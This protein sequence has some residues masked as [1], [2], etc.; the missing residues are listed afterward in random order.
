MRN[1]P[2]LFQVHLLTSRILRA[3]KNRQPNS[4]SVVLNKDL[5]PPKHNFLLLD[6]ELILLNNLLEMKLLAR[7]FIRNL[8][9]LSNNQVLIRLLVQAH[10]MVSIELKDLKIPLGQSVLARETIMKESQE[11]HRTSLHQILTTQIS[12]VQQTKVP[13]GFSVLLREEA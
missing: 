13:I 5:L 7:L 12:R 8:L 3:S 9:H 6:L 10:M 2:N 1:K 4:V 11:E